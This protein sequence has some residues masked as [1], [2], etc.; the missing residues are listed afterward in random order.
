MVSRDSYSVHLHLK[1]VMLSGSSYPGGPAIPSLTPPNI[2]SLSYFIPSMSRDPHTVLFQLSEICRSSYPEYLG[3]L[4]LNTYKS[5]ICHSLRFFI[6][7]LSR[8]PHT[9]HLTQIILTKIS[10]NFEDQKLLLKLPLRM[11][12]VHFC[13]DF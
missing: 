10:T 7:R 3:I 8:N 1:S 5:E 6:P 13:Q 2:K 12:F 4:T 11:R 9:E